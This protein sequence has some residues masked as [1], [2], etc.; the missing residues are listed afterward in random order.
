MV[1]AYE[2]LPQHIK[3]RSPA[4]ARVT[5]SRPA[6]APPCRSKTPALKTQYR[7]RST[8]RDIRKPAKVLFVNAFTTHFTNFRTPERV[9]SAATAPVRRSPAPPDQPG[10]HPRVPGALALEAQQHGDLGQPQ[11]STTP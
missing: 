1:L 2:R 8:L 10:V 11:R 3:R 4:C 9:A 5:A 7:T 6:S